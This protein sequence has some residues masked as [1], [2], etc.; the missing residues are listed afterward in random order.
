M[1]NLSA[2][3]QVWR[4]MAFGRFVWMLTARKLWLSRA[5]TLGDP[6]EVALSTDQVRQIVAKAPIQTIDD[7][8]AGTPHEAAS[9]RTERI[10]DE[11]KKSTYVSCWRVSDHESHAL[12]KLYCGS[13]EGIAIRT[14]LGRLRD[15]V[16]SL[17]VQPV[18]YALEPR[19]L[20]LLDLASTKRPAYAYEDEVRVISTHVVGARASSSSQ[21]VGKAELVNWSAEDNID[22]VFV[23][24]DADE[25]FISTVGLSLRSSRQDWSRRCSGRQCELRRHFIFLDRELSSD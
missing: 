24:P 6:W 22:A 17:Q 3:D 12:W 8:A 18:N 21:V 7:I 23:H 15:S 10:V 2:D 9:A 16:Q 5:D 13:P 19:S 20:S 14:T 1:R 11:W 25:Q 4:Y